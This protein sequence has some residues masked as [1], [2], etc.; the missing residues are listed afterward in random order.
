MER[1]VAGEQR[2]VIGR[3]TIRSRITRSRKHFSFAALHLGQ[4]N[5]I[6]NISTQM[7]HPLRHHVGGSP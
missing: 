5:I 1:L 7:S 2:L 6:G 4:Q 3:V